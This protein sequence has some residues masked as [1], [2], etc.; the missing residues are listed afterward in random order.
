MRIKGTSL[1]GDWLLFIYRT[2]ERLLQLLWGI[3]P[4]GDLSQCSFQIL[5]AERLDVPV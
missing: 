4:C 5:I 1:D 2:V 3:L